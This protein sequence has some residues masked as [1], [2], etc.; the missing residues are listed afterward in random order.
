MRCPVLALNG[1]RDCQVIPTQNLP[2]IARALSAGGNP[3][4]AVVELPGLNHLF[5]ECATGSPTEYAQIEQTFSPRALT[6][7]SDWILAHTH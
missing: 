3:D 7:L 2:E 1:E 6:L 5:Q 4:W